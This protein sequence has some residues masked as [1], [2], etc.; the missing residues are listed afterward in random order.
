MIRFSRCGTGTWIIPK[1]IEVMI[2][3]ERMKL[4]RFNTLLTGIVTGIVLPVIV[5]FIVYYAVIKDIGSTL[6]SNRQVA[7]NI[8]PVI[9]SHCVI[10]D[11]I[12]FM[13]F[14][15]IDWLQAAKGVLGA[16]VFMTL[17]LFG[18]K[19]ILHVF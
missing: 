1:P 13:I 16:T 6:V 2:P 18:L 15:R 5:Y 3:I 19:L 7:G 9:I 14:N 12:L 10:P 11:L 8:L 4:N 17:S